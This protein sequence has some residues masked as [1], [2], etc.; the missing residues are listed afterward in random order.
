MTCQAS[1]PAHRIFHLKPIIEHSKCETTNFSN[2]VS[3]AKTPPSKESYP[4]M[5]DNHIRANSG[6]GR[7]PSN[8]ISTFRAA[9]VVGHIKTTLYTKSV[10]HMPIV[11]SLNQLPT[12]PEPDSCNCL[13]YYKSYQTTRWLSSVL[14]Q[15]WFRV[16]SIITAHRTLLPYSCVRHYI[17]VVL[18]WFAM[19]LDLSYWINNFSMS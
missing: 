5:Y 14:H 9:E 17:D 6:D 4:C 3:L 11:S 7:V 10:R 1:T 12:Y 15:L 8:N 13:L 2:Y 16:V 19:P 18:R